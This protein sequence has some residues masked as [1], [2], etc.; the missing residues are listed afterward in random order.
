ME[1]QIRELAR[2][3]A[4]KLFNEKLEK[5]NL[6]PEHITLKEAKDQYNLFGA[7]LYRR[8]D[9]GH[10]SLIKMGGKS[11]LIRKEVEKLFVRVK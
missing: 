5:L 9:E 3:E 11:F 8:V 2:Q 6:R 10:L 1:D 7:T 4:E